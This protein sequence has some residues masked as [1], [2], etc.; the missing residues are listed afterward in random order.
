MR[1]FY[2]YL[3]DHIETEIPTLKVELW[4]DQFRKA[5]GEG[6]DGRKEK[7]IKYPICYIEMVIN[8]VNNFSQ[9]FKDYFTTVRFR[10]GLES[11][12]FERLETFDFIDDFY[13]AI[14]FFRPALSTELAFTSFQEVQP[15]YDTDHHNVEIPTVDYRTKIRTKVAYKQPVPKTIPTDLEIDARIKPDVYF[16]EIGEEIAPVYFYED[17]E[18]EPVH[19]HEQT[20]TWPAL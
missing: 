5:N 19:F 13:R 2:E 15:V 10:F 11:Y 4:N 6:E 1:G 18:N 3:R 9:G 8:Q 12:K 20:T 7:P 16:S 14:H 17:A